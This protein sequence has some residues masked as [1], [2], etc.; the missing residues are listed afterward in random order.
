MYLLGSLYVEDNNNDK[1]IEILKK[2]IAVD[3]EHDGSLNTLGYLYAEEGKNLDEAQDLIKCAIELSP[4]NG[5]YLDS[6]GWVYYKKGM[7][8]E[9]A[10]AL[11]NAD[12]VMKDP[13]IYDHLGDVYI[14]MNKT[15]EAIKYWQSSLE[16]DPGQ[17]QIEKKIEEA[18]SQP[19]G[20]Q[21]SVSN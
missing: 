15:D 2:S 21:A 14:K 19:I 8:E 13:V 11:L 6:L 9:A 17:A 3:P 16:L 20:A 1:A 10:Q 5:A 18:K 12:K 7:Y 4:D